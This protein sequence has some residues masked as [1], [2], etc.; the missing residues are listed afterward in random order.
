MVN[1]VLRPISAG[2][3]S[4]LGDYNAQQLLTIPAKADR[5]VEHD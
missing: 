4:N 2:R 3:A 1:G 5:K